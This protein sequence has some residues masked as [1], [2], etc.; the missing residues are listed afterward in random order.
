[1][2]KYIYKYIVCT[3]RINKI[4]IYNIHM[5]HVGGLKKMTLRL[6]MESKYQQLITRTKTDCL[7]SSYQSLDILYLYLFLKVVFI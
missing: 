5:Q 6:G 2:C 3:T 7:C 4:Y 1:M